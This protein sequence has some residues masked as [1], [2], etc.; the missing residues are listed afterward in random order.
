MTIYAI[1]DVQGCVSE[2]DQLVDL[3]APTS[4]DALWFVGDLVNRGPGSLETLRY[5]KRLGSQATVVLGNHDLHL[6]AIAHGFGRLKRHDTLTPILEAADRLEL[7]EWLCHRPLVH[8][9]ETTDT[10]LVHAG[11]PPGWLLPAFIN[12]ASDTQTL[13][14]REASRRT[15]LEHMYGNT[16]VRWEDAGSTLE[17]HRFVINA[18]TR[19]RLCDSIGALELTHKDAPNAARHA[20]LRPWFDPSIRQ[21]SSRI[22][23]GHWSTLGLLVREDL[24]ATDTGCV[25]GGQLTAVNL[26]TN[27][28]HQ[29]ASA[30]YQQPGTK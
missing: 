20:G 24:V 6:I 12:A 5:I 25:W 18:C 11:I 21:V 9:C 1:G 23:F 7:I 28:V 4:T 14:R 2:L 19:M 13:L 10:V 26:N 3:I 17:Q 30:G 27:E 29:I 22:V 15:L 16:P 8:Y